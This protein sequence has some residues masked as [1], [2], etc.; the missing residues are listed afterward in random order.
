[1][2]NFF[3]LNNRIYDTYFTDLVENEPSVWNVIFLN[4]P[5]AKSNMTAFHCCK[6]QNEATVYHLKSPAIMHFNVMSQCVNEMRLL[7]NW[8]RCGGSWR[9]EQSINQKPGKY[10]ERSPEWGYHPKA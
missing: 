7:R 10:P 3:L 2:R 8:A 4:R 5:F 6:A 1:M 9:G